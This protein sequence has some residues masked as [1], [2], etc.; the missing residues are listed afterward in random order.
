M[1]C[2]CAAIVRAARAVRERSGKAPKVE[3]MIPLVAY[4][5]ELELARARVLAVAEEEGFTYGHD[6]GVGTMIE[7]PRACFIADRIARHADFFSFGTN[8]LTQTA[9]GFSRDDVEGRIIPRYVTEKILDI[10]PFATID[11]PGV[12]ELVRTAA[13]LG[14]LGRRRHRARHLRGARRRSR[15]DPVL[16]PRRPGLRQLLAVPAPDRSRRCRP[17]GD[18]RAAAAQAAITPPRPR[19]VTRRVQT[20]AF[21]DR[22]QTSCAQTD[23]TAP[24]V[25]RIAPPAGVRVSRLPLDRL[26][27]RD[28]HPLREVHQAARVTPLVV[29]PR[30]DFHLRTVDHVVRPESKIDEYEDPTMSDETIG[31]SV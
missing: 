16:S 18:S 4:E 6:F 9:I 13:R 26:R 8:D 30:H 14:R 17:S 10:S 22:A 15:F 12:G 25:A 21:P 20:S 19:L 2:R 31:S 11:E 23:D 1:R 27:D 3:I 29:V 24:A 7:L 28:Q 5:R